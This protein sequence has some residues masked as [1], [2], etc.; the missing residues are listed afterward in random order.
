MNTRKLIF[1]IGTNKGEDAIFYA[2]MGYDVIAVDADPELIQANKAQ[3]KNYDGQ[4]T[5]L[6]YAI[7]GEDG[8]QLE[9]YIN[10]DSGMTSLI[11]EVGSRQQNLAA[12]AMV[13]TI[14]LRTLIKRYGCPYYC[15]IDIEGFDATAVRSMQGVGEMP[16]YISVEA[17]CKPE[18]DRFSED[19]IFETLDT[20]RDAGYSSFKLI[21]QASLKVLDDKDRYY[22]SSTTLPYRAIRKLQKLTHVYFGSY[23]HKKVLER[24]H[25]HPFVYSASGPFGEATDGE[26]MDYEEAKKTYLFQRRQYF[27]I[28]ANR[29]YSYWA[30]WHA[31]F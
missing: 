11:E 7:A 27:S 25:G 2:S 16:A 13:D 4:I 22:K 17:E 23:N 15:K 12:T 5:F 8:Q 18:D 10:G 19:G 9:L 20:L 28:A 30:D 29:R 6:N 3:H 1:D 21:D 14:T 24:V 26:W 31:K